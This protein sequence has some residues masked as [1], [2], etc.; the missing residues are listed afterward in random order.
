MGVDFFP[1]ENA[2]R[3]YRLISH[4][5]LN[6]SLLSLHYPCSLFSS[7]RDWKKTSVVVLGH[8]PCNYIIG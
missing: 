7:V 8:I 3:I 2:T 1:R 6:A 5:T 4:A